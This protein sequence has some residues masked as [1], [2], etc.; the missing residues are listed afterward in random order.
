LYDELFEREQLACELQH[1]GCLFVFHDDGHM[2]AYEATDRMT[3]ERF[4]VGAERMGR[5]AL[6]GFEPALQAEACAGGWYY[7]QDRHLRPDRLVSSWLQRLREMGVQI[8]GGVRVD[9]LLGRERAEGIRAEGGEQIRSDAVVMAAGAI[10][11][12]FAKLLG[13]RL[14]IQPGKG[15]SITMPRPGRCPRRPLI[16]Q[17]HKVAVT[18]MESGYRIGSTME[19]AGYDTSINSRRLEILREAA[20][21]YLHEPESAPIEEQWFGW[22]SMTTD[23]LPFIDRS[24]AWK[25]VYIAAGHN[26]LG[27]TM[28]PVTGKL[29]AE[30]VSGAPPHIDPGPYAVGRR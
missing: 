9:G 25:N 5:E 21:I 13:C 14:P 22:R 29:I 4:G 1:E 19:F 15:Y 20:R 16:F 24:P 30:M 26:M 11:P 28:A 17:D 10:M 6:V 8:R 27:L 18:P 23:G 12:Q 2:R 3:R 7:P